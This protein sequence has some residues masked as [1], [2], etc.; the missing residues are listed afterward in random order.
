MSMVNKFRNVISY[1]RNRSSRTKELTFFVSLS[2]CL[3]LVYVSFWLVS[4]ALSLKK[5]VEGHVLSAITHLKAG[6]EE[7]TGL[8]LDK[9]QKEFGSALGSFELAEKE[10]SESGQI[11]KLLADLH[12][13]AKSGKEIIE[14]SKKI[15]QAGIEATKLA[16][17]YNSLHFNLAGGSETTAAEVLRGSESK[18]FDVHLQISDAEK[19][20]N[21]IDPGTLPKGEQDKLAEVKEKV[22]RLKSLLDS[23]GDM[24]SIMRGFFSGSKKVLILFQNN[25]ELR[26]T[27]GFIGT[28][29]LV[30]LKD[31]TIKSV[32]VSSIYDLDGQLKK[33]VI[34]PEP[35][36]AV[37][38][39]WFMRDSNWFASFP[40]S[41]KKASLF[42]ERE[43]GETPDLVIALTPELVVRLLRITGPIDMPAYSI[44]MSSE[45]FIDQTQFLTSVAYDKTINNP[46][47]MI[48]DFIPLFLDKLMSAE[49]DKKILVLESLYQLLAEKHILFYARDSKV[50]AVFH[51]Y[52]WNG[53]VLETSSDYLMVNSSNLS[54]TKTDADIKEEVKLTSDIE[55]GGAILNTVS[56]TRSNP[57][58]KRKEF[59]NLAYIR[60]FV[61][62][63]STIISADGFSPWPFNPR[64]IRK[65]GD[66]DP[67][68]SSMELASTMHEGSRTVVMREAGKVTFGNWLKLEGGESKTVTI[69]YRLPFKITDTSPYELLAQIQPGISNYSFGYKLNAP[70]NFEFIQ[71]LEGVIS[72]DKKVFESA[73]KSSKRDTWFGVVVNEK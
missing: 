13:S 20:L 31:G 52:N 33:N 25:Q 40:D 50:Q 71:G 36:F 57:L 59:E 45:N 60:V 23:V 63:G 47:A 68:V 42:F 35:L 72:K 6:Q 58:E 70:D 49:G 37:N 27:G 64:D 67:E 16:S 12:P 3:F 15:S 32:K 30:D 5:R 29:G 18:L 43:G 19:I 62:N 21:N 1:L 10:F 7:V 17:M 2:V 28:Y 53:K 39:K 73:T 4:D 66:M 38:N 8:N 55:P 41:A 51:K 54:G 34:P 69:R 56:I 61:P 14:A 22:S 26:A 44:K 46:K 65:D 9:A 48:A 11:L 24:L